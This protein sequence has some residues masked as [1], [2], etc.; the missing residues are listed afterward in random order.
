MS[1]GSCTFS[2]YPL[3]LCEVSFHSNYQFL[4]SESDNVSDGRTDRQTDK[5]VTICSTL[6]EH[7]NLE[8]K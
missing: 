4:S 5:A 1:Y 2:Y 3:S 6:G 8:K 7:K